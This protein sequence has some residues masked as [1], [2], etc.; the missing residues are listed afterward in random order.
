MA[1]AYHDTATT[2]LASAATS[3]DINMPASA[4]GELLLLWMYCTI[5]PTIAI[6]SGWNLA[7]RDLAGYEEVSTQG[8]FALY[9]KIASSSE[10]STY[11]F[12]FSV[13]TRAVAAVSSYSGVNQINPLGAW[14]INEPGG[15]STTLTSTKIRAVNNSWISTAAG[16][17]KTADPGATFTTDDAS[18]V[19]RADL[20]TTGG[21][22]GTRPSLAVWDSNRTG[23][24]GSS[25]TR[26]ITISAAPVSASQIAGSV[27]L[28]SDVQT[29][30][31]PISYISYSTASATGSGSATATVSVP[32][33][34]TAGDLLIS[35]ATSYSL[36]RNVFVD[37]S[38]AKLAVWPLNITY[39]LTQVFYKIATAGVTNSVF[40]CQGSGSDYIRAT[41]LAYR[42]A[43][44]S[45]PLYSYS[46]SG[47]DAGTSISVPSFN[48]T[49]DKSWSLFSA[50]RPGANKTVSSTN[51]ALDAVRSFATGDE[52]VWI[53]DSNRSLSSGTSVSR[54]M[55][56]DDPAD[57]TVMGVEIAAGVARSNASVRDASGAW[58]SLSSYTGPDIK[59]R[60]SDGW[61]S[62]LSPTATDV[63]IK[64]STGAWTS[65]LY[66]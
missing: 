24:A 35:I 14:I 36:G 58:I 3:L 60:T 11:T 52:I 28:I 54:T 34:A 66:A 47:S 33:G 16:C 38:W 29:G 37:D 30:T 45:S 57:Y 10:P 64:S 51:D 43:N 44:T 5:H 48:T 32:S 40:W 31:G 50:T 39:N 6:P 18:D 26:T 53:A 22:S 17:R 19:E 49:K 46:V 61:V 1:I 13:A 20:T 56:T 27:E 41:I 15:T 2:Q 63:K 65:I 8:N 12:T 9:W 25:E 42:G 7:P 4:S 55:T 59:L 23:T 62:L 21:T